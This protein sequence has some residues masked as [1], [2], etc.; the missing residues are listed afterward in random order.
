MC[1]NGSDQQLIRSKHV[2]RATLVN[3]LILRS[4]LHKSLASSNQY[5][6]I[7][8]ISGLYVRQNVKESVLINVHIF[9]TRLQGN[10]CHLVT[11]VEQLKSDV[12][13]LT[14]DGDTF[15][16]FHNS[17]ITIIMDPAD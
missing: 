13:C 8:L 15:H 6:L 16:L 14:P 5:T 10:C 7:D 2:Q 11:S 9:F 1:Q 3:V 12:N 17:K 4:Q